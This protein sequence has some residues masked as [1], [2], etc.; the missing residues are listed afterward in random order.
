M[1]P[2]FEFST[3]RLPP[4]GFGKTSSANIIHKSQSS[5]DLGFRPNVEGANTRNPGA[6][7]C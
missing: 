3:D 4:E 5:V 2:T 7:E 6:D 1:M